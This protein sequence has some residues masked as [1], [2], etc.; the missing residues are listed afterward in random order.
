MPLLDDDAVPPWATA[1]KHKA[2]PTKTTTMA[3]ATP[4]LGK[5]RTSLLIIYLHS[6]NVL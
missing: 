6:R 2:A 3:E 4:L 1:L 5:L